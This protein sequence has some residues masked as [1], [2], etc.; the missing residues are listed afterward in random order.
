MTLPPVMKRL[1]VRLVLLIVVGLSLAAC[2]RGDTNTG[3]RPANTAPSGA[4]SGHTA[5]AAP[6]DAVKLAVDSAGLY[7]VTAAELAAA[8]FD[9]AGQDMAQLSLTVGGAPVAFARRSAPMVAR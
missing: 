4:S 2:S 5:P 3:P 1:P 7:R 6:V 8:G 9:L